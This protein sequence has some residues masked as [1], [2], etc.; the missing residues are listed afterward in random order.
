MVGKTAVQPQQ[1]A[2]AQH[3]LHATTIQ[4]ID[5][6]AIAQIII[7]MIMAIALRAEIIRYKQRKLVDIATRFDK[8]HKLTKILAICLINRQ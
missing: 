3:R 4:I 7:I 6:E 5:R 2:N 8:N 1:M